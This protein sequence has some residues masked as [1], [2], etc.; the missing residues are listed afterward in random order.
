MNGC[1]WSPGMVLWVGGFGAN[2][3]GHEQEKDRY[4]MV[5]SNEKFNE[6]SG[7]VTLAPFATRSG[8]RLTPVQV[9]VFGPKGSN[10]LLIEQMKTIDIRDSFYRVQY[11]YT[12]DATVWAKVQNGIRIHFGLPEPAVDLKM[13]EDT[14]SRLLD[15][16]AKAKGGAHQEL[17]EETTV[18]ETKVPE[19][20]IVQDESPQVT[21]PELLQGVRRAPGRK[22]RWTKEKCEKFLNDCQKKPMREVMKIW[23]IDSPPQFYQRRCYVEGVYQRILSEEKSS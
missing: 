22:A 15:K 3:H 1:K 23:S 8:K 13:V 5:L 16:V 10:V 12:V 19:G 6:S 11:Q 4:C 7:M 18:V 20:K 9:Q 14:V 21:G 17:K 2:A